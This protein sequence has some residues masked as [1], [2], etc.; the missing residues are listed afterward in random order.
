[1][2]TSVR[3]KNNLY[4]DITNTYELINSRNKYLIETALNISSD[5]IDISEDEY[6]NKNDPT[7][8]L[9]ISDIPNKQNRI[10]RPK[11]IIISDSY[12]N[13]AFPI[14][15]PRVDTFKFDLLQLNTTF[16]DRY[17]NFNLHFIP[18]HFVIEF[19]KTN[20]FIF[21]TR[22]IN[23]QFPLT[24]DEVNSIILK[25]SI[26]IDDR[27]K[28]F[29]KYKP[30]NFKDAIHILIIGDSNID[31]YT[32]QIYELMSYNCINPILQQWGYPK[33]LWNKIWF[34]NIGK[35]FNIS[36]MEQY[37]KPI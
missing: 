6:I 23:Q 14:K 1:M 22:P 25:N 16:K 11:G 7:S 27:T 17:G 28:Q 4:I 10:L 20:Y 3:N 15:Y 29:L 35:K 24:T 36:V 5:Q 18:W 31:I 21:N 34:L 13:I 37:I 19:I 26:T 30:F 8:K 32:N 33:T 2:S 9:I 12:N